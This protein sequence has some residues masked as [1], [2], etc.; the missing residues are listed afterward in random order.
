MNKRILRKI[1][2]STA[3]VLLLSVVVCFLVIYG[4]TYFS[5][6][7][8][9]EKNMKAYNERVEA[10]QSIE[11]LE[12]AVGGGEGLMYV[13]VLS[14]E[15]KL[16]VS[17]STLGADDILVKDPEF[18]QEVREKGT[19]HRLEK[20]YSDGETMVIVYVSIENAAIDE[21]GYVVVAYGMDMN[22]NDLYFWLAVGGCFAGLIIIAAIT[23]AI[24]TNYI[25]DEVVPLEKIQIMLENFNKGNYKPVNYE[26]KY[27]EINNIVDNI[28]EAA[29]K[30][31]N[32]LSN[33]RYEKNKTKFIIENVA[34]GIIALNN[35]NKILIS[36]DVVAEIFDTRANI[37]GVPIDYLIKDEKILSEIAKAVE[38]GSNAMAGE[39]V[40]G[41][42]YYRVDCRIVEDELYEE[43]K[44][45]KYI[46]L[47]TDVTSE[48]NMAKVRS[49]FFFNASHELKSPLT[50]IMGFSELMMN[51][52]LSAENRSKCAKDI[53]E[54]SKRMATLI[55]KMITLGKLDS[56]QYAEK[57]TEDVDLRKTADEAL[58]RLKI[59]A[60][61][62][63]VT[64]KC[65]G[66]AT[67]KADSNQMYTLIS[68]L[69]SNAIKYNKENGT[70]TVRLSERKDKV[71][72]S[73]E[74]TGVGIAKKDI[75]HLCERFYRV[76]SEHSKTSLDS[77][78]LGLAIVKQIV[79]EYGAE[80]KIESTV[81]K[82]SKFT[83]IFKR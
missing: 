1:F 49:E 19:M 32:T 54:S 75:P 73:V 58:K 70:V 77:N 68:N 25:K 51:P 7:A 74:D 50:A 4:I 15:G 3:L 23:Y 46:L 34:Q 79:D 56:A 9:I 63:G 31:S 41:D 20:F 28:N 10:A 22:F 52:D 72:V 30:I 26:A 40:I 80:L 65:E 38:S 43:Y 62:I 78:G 17:N 24:F 6:H 61:S 33:L 71:S 69:V 48:A 66:S 76:K 53:H 27:T 14:S 64:M 57:V 37:V 59:I 45:I 5:K 29:N 60:D 55:E 13:G 16:V 18:T 2:W 67:I 83:I 47:I 21:N 12:E 82:G 35:Q 81:G 39:T 42:K 11:E 36:N 8:I 44:D